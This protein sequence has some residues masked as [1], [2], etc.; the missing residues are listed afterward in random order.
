MAP[1][2]STERAVQHAAQAPDE[3]SIGAGGA[4]DSAPTSSSL[5]AMTRY[6]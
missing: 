4:A 6:E 3:R 2:P 5:N 1:S